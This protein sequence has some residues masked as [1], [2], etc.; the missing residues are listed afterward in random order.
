MNKLKH[1]FRESKYRYLYLCFLCFVTM[2]VCNI[3]T[4]NCRLFGTEQSARDIIANILTVNVFTSAFVVICFMILNKD[5][6]M[7]RKKHVFWAILVSVLYLVA[8]SF[9]FKFILLDEMWITVPIVMSVLLIILF[10]VLFSGIYS[11]N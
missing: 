5:L 7:F 2:S 3:V 4:G 11:K 8:I 6:A 9:V 1:L 10:A